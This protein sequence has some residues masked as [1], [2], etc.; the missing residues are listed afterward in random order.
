MAVSPILSIP[1]TA[2]TQT[3][4]TTTMNDAVVQLEGALQDQLVLDFTAGA[5]T[6]TTTQFTRFQVFV[7]TNVPSTRALIIPL[8][9]RVFVVRNTGAAAVTVGGTT[10]ATFVVPA[11]NGAVIQCTGFDTI[12]YGTGGPG[13][14]G[15]SGSAGGGVSMVYQFDA[16]TTNADP[17]A[18]R[19]RL[20]ATTQNAST[21]IYLDPIDLTG[22]DWTSVLASI[23][24]GTSTEKGTV[25]LYNVLDTTKFLVFSVTDYISHTGYAELTVAS[26]GSSTASPFSSLDDLGFTF[27]RTGDH[28]TTWRDGTGAPSSSLGIDGD[29]YLDHALGDVYVRAFGTYTVTANIKGPTGATGATGAAG[30]AGSVWRNGIGA[31]SSG[32][33]ING[34]LYL[35]D[36]TGDVSQKISGTYTVIANIMGPTG[37]PGS[38]RSAARMQAQWVSGAIVQND[39]IFFAYDPPYNGTINS[40]TYFTGVGSF[41]VAVKISGTNVTGLSAVLVNNTTAATATAT[42]ANTFTA[43]QHITAAITSA[44]SSPTDALLSLNVTWS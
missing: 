14:P 26:I 8:T 38:A 43:G 2:P 41:T 12:G 6:L 36:T 39:T 15:V 21:G 1:L 9:K 24:T 17:G 7:C 5:I 3:D 11:G 44:T 10:G 29:Y 34:D 35:N 32:L 23:D 28:G 31:P 4:K 19:L 25:R 40:L 18:G 42:A 33:G 27:T 22:S 16:T 37:A 30:A 20:S 13:P